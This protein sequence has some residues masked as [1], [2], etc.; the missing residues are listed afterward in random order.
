M[1]VTDDSN[2]IV[3]EVPFEWSDI[4]GEALVLEDGT[5]IPDVAASPDLA[6]A[7]AP[8]IEVSATDVSVIDV[9]TAMDYLAKPECTLADSQL[10]D[11]GV[12][13]GQ[14]DFY[15]DCAA[16]DA[17]YVL[18]AASYNPDPQRIAILQAVLVTDSDV[19]AM[20]HALDTFNFA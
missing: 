10:Y 14:I 18:L 15:T 20:T 17:V 13:E 1:R 7:G 3:V 8:S 12:F 19:D 4:N 9:P 6:A 16:S 5:Y 2:T 11:D